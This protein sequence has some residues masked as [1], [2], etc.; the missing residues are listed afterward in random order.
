MRSRTA[1]TALAPRRAGL[2]DCLGQGSWFLRFEVRGGFF[3][4]AEPDF[5]RDG[6]A[7]LFEDVPDQA[8][9]ARHD[10]DAAHRAPVEPELA[11][12]RAD[13]ARSVDDELLLPAD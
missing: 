11:G 8:H 3:L 7:R 2:D 4:D 6:L 10:A 12:E 9:G 5:F 13:G 1:C